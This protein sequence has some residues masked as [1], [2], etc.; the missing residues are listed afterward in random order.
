MMG[1]LVAFLHSPLWGAAITERSPIGA[2]G[3]DSHSY[4]KPQQIVLTRNVIGTPDQTVTR[5]M[6]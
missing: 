2:I 5:R 6:Y 3:R 4:Y 1:P